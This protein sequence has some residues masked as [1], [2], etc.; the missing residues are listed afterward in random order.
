[1]FDNVI[2]VITVL[3]NDTDDTHQITIKIQLE[4]N[5]NPI[6]NQTVTDDTTK[7]KQFGGIIKRRQLGVFLL[8]TLLRH[9][10][11]ICNF[12][13]PPFFLFLGCFINRF[14]FT[15]GFI[16]IIIRFL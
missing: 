12:I 5:C 1:M 9:Y 11:L 2:K 7:Q 13:P 16:Y 14:G 15:C 3:Y 8:N 4:L 10:K 6:I